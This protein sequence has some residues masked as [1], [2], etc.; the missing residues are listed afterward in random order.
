[1]CF[2]TN[3]LYRLPTYPIYFLPSTI[4]ETIHIIFPKLKNVHEYN[5]HVII[6]NNNI[7]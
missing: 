7:I 6:L 4:F 5:I 3:N 1:M 2:N